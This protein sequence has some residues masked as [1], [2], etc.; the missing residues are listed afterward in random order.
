MGEMLTAAVTSIISLLIGWLSGYAYAYFSGLKAVRKGMQLLLRIT[1]DALYQQFI[2]K[3]PTVD[4][5]RTF[6]EIYTIYEKLSDNGV[7][8]AKHEEVLHMKE[9]K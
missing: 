1:L 5:K 9:R 4:E 2:M 7:M 3:P 6:E 8:D